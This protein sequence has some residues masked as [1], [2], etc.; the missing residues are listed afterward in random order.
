[1]DEWNEEGFF[2]PTLM[3]AYE[4]GDYQ[5]DFVPLIVYEN[6]PGIFLQLKFTRNARTNTGF[7][8][9][10]A[11]PEKEEGEEDGEKAKDEKSKDGKPA[12]S[13]KD[14]TKKDDKEEEKKEGDDKGEKKEG[15]D[16][17]P[18]DKEGGK[19]GKGKEG[20]KKPKLSLLQQLG[21]QDPAKA[22]PMMQ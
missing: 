15:D 19:D 12:S 13:K 14:P 4:I 20:E 5:E 7:K 1:M 6:H 16:S 8:L 10:K 2:Y 22:T 18:K 17:G 9:P 3:V 21:K 11:N